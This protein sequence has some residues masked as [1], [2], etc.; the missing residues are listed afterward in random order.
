MRLLYAL[1]ALPALVARAGP[2]S[3][4][5]GTTSPNIRANDTALLNFAL[6]LGNLQNAFYNQGL[7]QF[8]DSAFNSSGY[9][10]GIRNGFIQIGQSKQVQVALI[11]ET[12]GANATAPCTYNFP[13]DNVTTFAN[14]SQVIENIGTSAYIGTA[15]NITNATYQTIAASI[16]SNNA[17][18]ASWVAYQVNEV[19]PW[20]GPFDTP[21]TPSQVETLIAPYIVSCPGNLTG[22]FTPAGNLTI[23]PT[24]AGSNAT[25]IFNN[26]TELTGANASTPLFAAYLQG[27]NQTFV[28][29]TNGSATVPNNL[30]GI[31]YAAVTN[32]STVVS[33]DTT[34][35]GPAWINL[36]YRYNTTETSE[37][38]TPPTSTTSIVTV[39][40]T[41]E[42]GTPPTS[43]TSVVTIWTISS[44]SKSDSLS[45][46]GIDG[47]SLISALRE[48]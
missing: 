30:T 28:P 2:V 3:R 12:L 48:L 36:S 32:S 13:L 1:I 16:L 10:P 37:G 41:S 35:A 26:V 27:L 39:T 44:Q 22:P 18:Y 23:P 20:D 43:T 9:G 40:E 29:I 47:V 14:L 6:S 11:N 7:S 46:S 4:H 19:E 25:F 8:D 42:G 31:V 34:V 5:G 45:G 15:Q 38:G 33:N 17:R 24:S 21:L